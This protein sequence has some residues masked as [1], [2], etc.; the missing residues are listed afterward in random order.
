MK[1]RKRILFIAPGPKY[2]LEHA[3]KRRCELLSEDFEGVFLTSGPEKANLRFG[4]FE[5]VS[6]RD[7]QGKSLKTYLRMFLWGLRRR[8][9]GRPSDKGF[10]LIISYDPLKTGVLALALGKCL[11]AKVIIEVNGCY[12]NDW[13]YADIEDPR[14]RRLKKKTF[15]A[16]ESF[17]LN[18]ADGIKLLYQEQIDAYKPLSAHID[19]FEDYVEAG[20]YRNLESRKEVLLAG[21]PAL[22]K[23]VDILLRAWKVVGEEFPD[24]TLK[25]LGYYPDKSE[26]LA[27]I[28]DDMRVEIHDPVDPSEMP[29]H[30]GRCGLFVLP[31]RTEAMGR[32]LIEAMAAEKARIGSRVGGIPTVIND[33]VDGLLVTPEDTEAL[34]AALRKL[35]TDPARR[36]SI[37]AA[38][39]QRYEQEFVETAYRDKIIR[40]YDEV[41]AQ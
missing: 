21:F 8:K 2:N 31:S 39:R 38:G 27:L 25:I 7:E 19:V 32:V 41:L 23:G 34:A 11:G 16:L 14:R 10:D 6:F 20:E 36:E 5:V 1:T 22:I 33:G 37:G 12:D 30:I 18:R 4:N 28:D 40:F 29:D 17:T 26:L 24:W 13:I 35:I 3:F 15:C 9:A